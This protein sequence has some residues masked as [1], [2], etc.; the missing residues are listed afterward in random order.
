[1]TAYKPNLGDTVEDADA[2]RIGK[3]MGFEGPYVQVRPVGGGREW[4]ARPDDLRPVTDAQAL[5]S[6]VAVANARSR[7]EHL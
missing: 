1:M 7:G 4:D 5:R 3:V 6:A 2:G